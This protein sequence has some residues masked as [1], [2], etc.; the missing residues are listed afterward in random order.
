MASYYGDW[1]NYAIEANEAKILG[2]ASVPTNKCGAERSLK[3]GGE[4]CQAPTLSKKRW[5]R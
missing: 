5:N 3:L 4:P 1:V 2:Q